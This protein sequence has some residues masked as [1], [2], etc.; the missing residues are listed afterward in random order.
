[1]NRR[2]IVLLVLVIGCSTAPVIKRFYYP[3]LPEA[4]PVTQYARLQNANY[5]PKITG[6]ITTNNAGPFTNVIYQTTHLKWN[7]DTNT[8]S[9]V[10]FSVLGTS[11]LKTWELIG[12]TTNTEFYDYDRTNHEYSY[13]VGA[14]WR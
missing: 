3:P 9:R 14:H 2:W 4:K 10:F 1:M 5:K 13:R 7:Y 8:L 11:D 6:F 12:L